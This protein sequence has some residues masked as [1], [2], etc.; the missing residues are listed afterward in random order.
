MLVLTR[1]DVR[2]LIRIDEVITA[3]ESAH[4]ALARGA[5]TQAIDHAAPLPESGGVMIPM[6]ATITA[7][8]VAGVKV[9]A[10]SAARIAAESRA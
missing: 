3:V 4:A 5:A 7:P 6:A 9:L 8:P 2:A 1:D 10:G